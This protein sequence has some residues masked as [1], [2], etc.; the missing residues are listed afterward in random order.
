MFAFFLKG[1]IVEREVELIWQKVRDIEK[2]LEEI[3]EKIKKLDERR[4]EL[5]YKIDNKTSFENELKEKLV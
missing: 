3:D 5:I 1:V 2:E 4:T